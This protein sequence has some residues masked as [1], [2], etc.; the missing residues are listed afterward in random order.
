MSKYTWTQMK[1]SKSYASVTTAVVYVPT[2]RT[3]HI[4]S[5]SGAVSVFP[6]YSVTKLS[7]STLLQSRWER[8]KTTTE[9]TVIKKD[10]KYYCYAG[11][12]HTNGA[13]FVLFFSLL[14]NSSC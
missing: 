9:P 14:A 8:K 4:H 6:H 5:S 12:W 10:S 2:D 11:F 1:D 7:N 3:M 13:L